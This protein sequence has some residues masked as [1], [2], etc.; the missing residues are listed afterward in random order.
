MSAGI[1]FGNASISGFPIQ[2]AIGALLLSDDDVEEMVTSSDD[3]ALSGR[4]DGTEHSW[5]GK[6]MPFNR[7]PTYSNVGEPGGHLP[8]QS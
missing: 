5:Q 1:R 4:P 6:S 8:A 7:V 3:G 2:A